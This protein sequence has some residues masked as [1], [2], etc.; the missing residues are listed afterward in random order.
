MSRDAAESHGCEVND[1]EGIERRF[2]RTVCFVG[3][4]RLLLVLLTLHLN[5]SWH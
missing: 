4:L 2:W 1:Y 5:R 3:G